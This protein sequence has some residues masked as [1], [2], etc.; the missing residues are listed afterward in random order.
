MADRKAV[1]G[2]RRR[3]GCPL[4]SI[5][6]T[7]FLLGLDELLVLDD[8]PLVADG[9]VEPDGGV[10]R[11]YRAAAL[12]ARA[13]QVALAKDAAHHE[14]WDG[15]A[16]YHERDAEDEADCR[17]LAQRQTKHKPAYKEY[18]AQRDAERE[19]VSSV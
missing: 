2:P 3:G 11:V 12:R 9:A 10:R 19:A 16:R 14:E 17:T 13:V 18:Q 6:G 7:G 8:Q 15:E 5:Y 1:G 4:L